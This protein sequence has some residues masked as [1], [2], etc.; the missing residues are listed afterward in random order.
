MSIKQNQNICPVFK[1]IFCILDIDFSFIEGA[2][3]L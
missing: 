2:L 1:N 3:I